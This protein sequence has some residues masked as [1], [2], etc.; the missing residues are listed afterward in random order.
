MIK[1]KSGR[2]YIELREEGSN[3]V[4][5]SQENITYIFMMLGSY[6]MKTL[7]EWDFFY[8]VF[9]EIYYENNILKYTFFTKDQKTVNLC[10]TFINEKF[11][12]NKIVQDALK[13]VNK[14]YFYIN[15][16][17]VFSSRTGFGEETLNKFN[18]IFEERRELYKKFKET[19]K[20]NEKL[21]KEI[22]T[23]KK[24]V[25]VGKYK[26]SGHLADQ[27]LKYTYPK[28]IKGQLSIFDSLE[29][30][31][32]KAIETVGG[33]EVTEIVEGIKL[34]ASETKIIDCLCKLLHENSQTLEPKKEDYYS[35]NKPAVINPE[36]NKSD[37]VMNYAGEPTTASKLAITLYS[38][39]KE[40][41]GGEAITGKDVENVSKTL[42]DLSNK[43]F[44]LKYKEETKIKNGNRRVREI[45]L[46]HSILSLPNYR[47]IIYNK[48]GVELSKREETL[49]VLHPIFKRQIDSKFILY[50]NDINKRTIIANGGHKIPEITLRLRE[51]LVRLH[52]SPKMSREINLD[53]LYYLLN[54]KYMRN[55]RK[56]KVKQELQR[57][58]ETVKAL[59]LLLDYKI[60]TGATGEPKIIF[61]L[62]KDWE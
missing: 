34:S 49:I 3:T 14:G 53:R 43:K 5:L 19:E 20:K 24:G 47:D 37:V 23:L 31:T 29:D 11:L 6:D 36:T 46:Y 35:G 2:N 22:E 30:A 40:Y 38:L 21:K 7:K 16:N 25:K 45:E 44:L 33:V 18:L 4:I 55:N 60:E 28:D 8:D 1:F 58:I 57:A 51:Y 41:K 32:K 12:K 26:R 42:L 48:E 61:T 52:S 15:D 56:S 9:K 13:D 27:M 39:A 17:N 59:G 62:N 10:T 54:E 50:P